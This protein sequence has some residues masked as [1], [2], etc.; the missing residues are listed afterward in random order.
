MKVNYLSEEWFKLTVELGEQLPYAPTCNALVQYYVTNPPEGIKPYYYVE[1]LDG[2]IIYSKPIEIENPDLVVRAD[3][4][5]AA[6]IAAGCYDAS[7]AY[8][9]D[10]TEI[11]GDIHKAMALMPFLRSE[12][13]TGFCHEM[14]ERTNFAGLYST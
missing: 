7:K 1:I 8:M 14:S 12:A 2:R 13:F 3:Y 11:I 5:Q 4:L 6:R 9:Q 10:S